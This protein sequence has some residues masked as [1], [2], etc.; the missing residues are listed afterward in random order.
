MKKILS[1]A[2][3]VCVIASCSKTAENEPENQVSGGWELRYRT[4]GLNPTQT[5]P[6]G[7]G[8]ILKFI[9]DNYE[10]S[11]N[12]VVKK[13]GKYLTLIDGSAATETCSTI[14]PGEFE[15]RIIFMPD[16]IPPKKY[17]H[18]AG[19]TLKLIWGCAAVDA[20]TI[21]QYEKVAGN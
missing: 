4:I 2:I 5:F 16:T 13:S 10:L 17:Y 9:D 12:G 20:K 21:E 7:N 18:I 14:T 6:P 15:K 8:N 1:L 19:N 11:E 3:I